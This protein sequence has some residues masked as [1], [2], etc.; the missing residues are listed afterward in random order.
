MQHHAGS[1]GQKRRE[2]GPRFLRAVN[3]DVMTMV[4]DPDELKNAA[5]NFAALHNPFMRHVIDNEFQEARPFGY[6]TPLTVTAFELVQGDGILMNEWQQT[7]MN[8]FSFPPFE[9][10]TVALAAAITAAHDRAHPAPE[11]EGKTAD[12][13][14]GAEG[15]G[16]SRGDGGRFVRAAD[17]TRATAAAEDV[18]ALADLLAHAQIGHGFHL[19]FASLDLVHS[20]IQRA[21]HALARHEYNFTLKFRLE[22]LRLAQNT[23]ALTGLSEQDPATNAPWTPGAMY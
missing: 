4:V 22:L 18:A 7:A 20:S 21:N 2:H 12:S 5:E 15:T 17:A 19:G 6:L 11:V 23:P 16:A 9:E 3:G 14:E 1:S 8:S 10:A 13:A